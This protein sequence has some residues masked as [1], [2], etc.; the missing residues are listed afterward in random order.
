MASQAGKWHTARRL[1]AEHGPAG[2]AA[3]LLLLGRRWWSRGEPWQLRKPEW[4]RLEGCRFSTAPPVPA[5]IRY[6]LE[7]GLYEKPERECIGAFLD[8]ALPVV[9]LGANMGVVS[10]VTNRRLRDRARHVV[11]EANPAL[12]PLLEQHRTWNH[13][14]F[15]IRHCAL[16]YGSAMVEFTVDDADPLGSRVGASGGRVVAVPARTLGDLLAEAGFAECTLICDIEGMETELVAQELAVLT[17]SVRTLILEIHERQCGAD[18]TARMLRL[19]EQAGFRKLRQVH[20]T[21]VL[22]R[23]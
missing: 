6:L 12:L 7:D 1:L 15:T 19:L 9:E 2:V 14:G 11:V 4:V 8:P 21:L 13:S 20:D 17:A 10:C 5:G 3:H 18:A 22:A 23:G 16:A